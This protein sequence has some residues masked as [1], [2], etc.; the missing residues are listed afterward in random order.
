MYGSLAFVHTPDG[1]FTLKRAGF[2]HP[3]VTVR[4]RPDDRDI[5]VFDVSL[6]V[7]GTILF[8]DGTTYEVRR[9]K[10]LKRDWIVT[11]PDNKQVLTIKNV[12][13]AKLTADTTIEANPR[14]AKYLLL[15]DA[16]VWYAFILSVEEWA[17][18]HE[19]P[20]FNDTPAV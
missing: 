17:G 19:G 15:A 7:T 12:K 14:N 10:K 4:M 2:L 18:D 9:P 5:G 1:T 8:H 6:G 13:T 3:R 16:I 11:D 20:K